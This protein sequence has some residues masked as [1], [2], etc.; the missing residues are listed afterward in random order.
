VKGRAAEEVVRHSPTFLR[1]RWQKV[2]LARQ[3]G[4]QQVWE[5]KAARV[6]QV[7]DQQWSGPTYWLPWAK[8]VASGE[9]KYLLSKAPARAPVPTLVRVGFRRWNVEQA[10][11]LAK[12]E[13]GLTHDEGRDYTAMPRH[14]TLCLLMLTFV[15]EHSER[16]RGEKPGGDDGAG[17]RGVEPVVPGVARGSA[18]DESPPGSVSAD[19]PP[20]AAQPQGADV[21]PARQVQ[22]K[23]AA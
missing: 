7:Q 15:A 12:S 9:E 10:I 19:R 3:T 2:K 1:Q 13:I 6:W 4:G 5:V 17:V 11:R 22:A 16:L 8:N 20:S 14:Q 23:S 21:S 18:G